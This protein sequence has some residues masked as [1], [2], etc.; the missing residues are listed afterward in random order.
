MI[1]EGLTMADVPLAGEVESVELP[2]A[3][4]K[5]AWG[6]RTGVLVMENGEEQALLFF[7]NGEIVAA[8]ETSPKRRK[9]GEALVSGGYL[10]EQIIQPLLGELDI[11]SLM[12]GDVLLKH[13]IIGPGLLSYFLRIQM[14]E[15]ATHLLQWSEGQFA[16]RNGIVH[17][18]EEVAVRLKAESLVREADRA[19]TDLGRLREKGLRLD[20]IV[21]SRES[22]PSSFAI[23][24]LS[25]FE[26]K[27]LE[28]AEGKHSIRSIAHCLFLTEVQAGKAVDVL[29]SEGLVTLKSSRHTWAA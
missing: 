13:N 2:S 29:A 9:L 4:R 12:A 14:I 19:L 10:S 17:P 18:K 8:E 21:V 15:V 3:I 26:R 23:S 16:F 27:V 25:P 7:S 11:D 5:L 22:R 1:Y 20:S 28:K 24:D 6:K